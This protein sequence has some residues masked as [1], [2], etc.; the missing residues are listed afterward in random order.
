MA[1]LEFANTNRLFM[2]KWDLAANLN[3]FYCFGKYQNG[4]QEM[5]QSMWLDLKTEM[6]FNK[7]NKLDKAIGQQKE[8][9]DIKCK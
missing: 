8:D 4:N 5:D 6:W 9:W 7:R 2:A 3:Q 1:K